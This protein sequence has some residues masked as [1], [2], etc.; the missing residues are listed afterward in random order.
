[1]EKRGKYG[2]F[3]ACSNYPTC[4]YIQKKEKAAPVETGEL[5]PEC[6]SPLVKRKSR[7]G[8]DFIGCSNYPK[9]RYIKPSGRK[10]AEKAKDE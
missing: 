1:M 2:K 3:I 8:K 5:C 4:K 9:C 10:K 7:Y 6:G